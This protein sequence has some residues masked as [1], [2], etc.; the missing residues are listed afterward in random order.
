MRAARS[1]PP[2]YWQVAE[3][4]R[5]QHWTCYRCGAEQ[6]RS[7]GTWTSTR[8]P[9]SPGRTAAAQPTEPRRA[10]ADQGVVP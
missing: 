9:R 8:L 3:E 1:C 2:H 10:A 5:V 7:R 4:R 6:D